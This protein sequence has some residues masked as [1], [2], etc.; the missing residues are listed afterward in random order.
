[1]LSILKD[2]NPILRKKSSLIRTI[3]DSLKKLISDMFKVMKENNGIGL[4][5]IQVGI[6]L[7]MFVIS[8][9]DEDEV[10]INPHIYNVSDEKII[11]EE[12][13]LSSLDLVD[14]ERYRS[15]GVYY[16]N[17]KYQKEHMIFHGLW[18]V[19]IQHEYDHLN[20]ILI[21]DYKK[22]ED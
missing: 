4:S 20:G 3:D 6:P 8:I 1:M 14:V 18:S 5:C 7:T 9:E 21:T 10:F 15:I 11:L 12:G 19:C 13:C 16:I 17:S 22:K 2:N